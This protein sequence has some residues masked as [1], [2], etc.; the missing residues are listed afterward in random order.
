MQI[1][2]KIHAKALY[3][4]VYMISYHCKENK[5]H[6]RYIER[7]FYISCIGSISTYTMNKSHHV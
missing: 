1:F 3:D 7:H 5:T 4:I 2:I 6:G